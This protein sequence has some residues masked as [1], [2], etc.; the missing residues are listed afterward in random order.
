MPRS[1]GTTNFAPYATAPPVGAE[2]DGYWNSTEDVPYFSDG[3]KWI[4]AAGGGVTAPPSAAFRRAGAAPACTANTFTRMQMDTLVSSAGGAVASAGSTAPTGSYDFWCNTSAGYIQVGVAGYYMVVGVWTGTATQVPGTAAAPSQLAIGKYL[5]TAI[6]PQDPVGYQITAR[7]SIIA[8]GYPTSTVVWEGYLNAGDYVDLTFYPYGAGYTPAIVSSNISTD[9]YAPAIHISRML[10]GVQGP[11]GPTGPTGPDPTLAYA[12]YFYAYGVDRTLTT[13]TYNPI[14]WTTPT[15]INGFTLPNATDVVVGTTGKYRVGLLVSGN[16]T[17]TGA[18]AFTG[19]VAHYASNGSTI[20]QDR[21]ATGFP[22]SAVSNWGTAHADMV[23][24]AVAGDIIRS[25]CDPSGGAANLTGARTTLSIIPVGGAKG[26]TGA[27]GAPGGVATDGFRRRSSSAD[28]TVGNGTTTYMPVDQVMESSGSTYTYT[29][30]D[31]SIT[32]PN[33]GL[34][35]IKGAVQLNGSLAPTSSTYLSLVL[36]AV[37]GLTTANST[38]AA[39]D[40]FEVSWIGRLTAGDKIQLGFWNV[41]GGNLIIRSTTDGGITAPVSPTLS[42]WRV[43]SG[44]TGAAGPQ[45]IQGTTGPAGTG[46]GF[47]PRGEWA[48]ATAYAANDI[49]TKN[50]VAFL[51]MVGSTNVDPGNLP[52]GSFAAISDLQTAITN[53]GKVQTPF[54]PVWRQGGQ[55]LAY[56]NFGCWYSRVGDWVHVYVNVNFTSAGSAANLSMDLPVP[57][58]GA[59]GGAQLNSLPGA[60]YIW[61]GGN[62]YGMWAT[63]GSLGVIYIAMGSN[64][65]GTAVANGHNISG[66]F[67]YP[68]QVGI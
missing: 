58:R 68:A 52:S 48:S 31:R 35:E 62:N 17:A 15:Y 43:G 21:I 67:A 66:F 10:T 63:G 64:Y 41:S 2:G 34:Y 46:P 56:T 51:A 24:D 1:Y 36:N 39:Y 55:V 44:A 45:G 23:I 53:I 30:A 5:G 59:G 47:N 42:V 16:A 50:G 3:T 32:I 65:Y 54:Y 27:T 25:Y 26:D 4:K 61:N 13:N 29:S 14:S 40:T 37:R 19:R 18:N 9:P 57:Y 8:A 28:I 20:K 7:H 60:C 11:A 12:N 33:D 6:S 22:M 38:N 49:V